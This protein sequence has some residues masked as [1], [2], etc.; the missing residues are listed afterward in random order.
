[1]TG[2][3]FSVDGKWVAMADSSSN[4]RIQRT[5]DLASDGAISRKL[6]QLATGYK[7]VLFLVFAASRANIRCA[8]GH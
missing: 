4:M 2:L 7:L 8:S 3:G 6:T 1:M 5:A